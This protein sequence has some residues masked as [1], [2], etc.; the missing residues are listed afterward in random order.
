MVIP[1]V[2]SLAKVSAARYADKHEFE[3]V[4]PHLRGKLGNRLHWNSNRTNAEPSSVM[5]WFSS[6]QRIISNSSTTPHV[7]TTLDEFSVLKKCVFL[8]ISNLCI[9]IHR[10]PSLPLKSD[11]LPLLTSTGTRWQKRPQITYRKEA[12][13]CSKWKGHHHHTSTNKP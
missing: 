1:Y 8:P 2:P 9:T 11:S 6:H 12:S 13:W 10:G 7:S 5:S 3:T 4:L